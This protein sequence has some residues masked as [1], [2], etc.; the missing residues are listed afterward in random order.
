MQYV[1]REVELG[2]QEEDTLKGIRLR[3]RRGTEGHL[4]GFQPPA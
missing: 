1:E 4:S 2:V 3:A